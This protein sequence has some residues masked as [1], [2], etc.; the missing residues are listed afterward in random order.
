[1]RLLI[2]LWAIL[3]V[4]A[5]I[6]SA[7]GGGDEEEGEIHIGAL[8][9]QTGP[10][11]DVGTDYALGVQEAIEYINDTGGIN[12]KKI[13]LHGYDYGYDRSKAA[14]L[15]AQMKDQDDVI[16]ILGWGTGDTEALRA[17]V[18]DDQM[19]YVSASYSAHLTDPSVARYN[20]FNSS[21]YSS[22][23]RAALTAW[24]DEIWMKDARFQARRDAG[25]KPRLINFYALEHP[26]ANAPIQALK[27]HAAMLGFEI[28]PD[29]NVGLGDSEAA[30]Q[31]LAAKDF[32]PDVAWHGNTTASAFATVR[33]AVDND[34]GADWI[35]NNWGFDENLVDLLGAKAE[36]V[37]VAGVAPCA[38]Y[39]ED[40]AM[41]DKV[42]E[43]AEKMHPDAPKR[44]V[45]TIQAWGNVM[46]LAEA[47]KQADE[48]DD[49]SGEGILTKGFETMQ[50]FDVGLGFAPVT[51]T[52]SDHRGAHS[53]RVYVIR[54]GG[55]ELLAQVDLKAR[56]P[57]QWDDWIGY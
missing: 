44:L 42:K 27:E 22:N 36:A 26:Y 24:Y 20:F 45:R 1:M 47:L 53:P 29:Q 46:L 41:M 13:V 51:Y 48:A 11:S 3:L 32:A 25:E 5:L 39:G 7:C 17:S 57:D 38:F 50:G 4:A 12:G 18:A 9:D 49:L 55:F 33:D 10:T 40:V 16:A 15:Y 43:Y 52:S 23:A 37:N 28:G 35:I 31:V 56:W 2:K 6:L 21:D 30:T 34:L 54:D 14:T 8:Y 19:P